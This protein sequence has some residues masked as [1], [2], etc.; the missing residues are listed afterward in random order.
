M[1]HPSTWEQQCREQDKRIAE[2]E[3]EAGTVRTDKHADAECIGDLERENG[4]LRARVMELE[5]ALRVIESHR[6]KCHE[7]DADAGY[8]L[9]GFDEEDVRLMEW[10]ARA[11]LN[12]Q[13]RA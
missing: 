5:A 8:E 13:E 7:Y 11:A 3:E 10:Q 9:R 4:R 1:T 12:T 2:L 6:R